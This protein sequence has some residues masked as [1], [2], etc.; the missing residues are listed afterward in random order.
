MIRNNSLYIVFISSVKSK[1]ENIVVS[2]TNDSKPSYM[3]ILGV[4]NELDAHSI[5]F[6]SEDMNIISEEEIQMETEGLIVAIDLVVISIQET[7]THI[8]V[9]IKFLYSSLSALV[10][11]EGTYIQQN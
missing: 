11:Y 10:A 1:I 8:E 9:F 7:F 4:Y 3:N 2:Y 5:S 6:D